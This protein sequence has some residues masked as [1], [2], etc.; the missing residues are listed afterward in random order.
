MRIRSA[1]SGVLFL[2]LASRCAGQEITATILGTVTDPSGAVVAGAT[3]IVTNTD[4]GLVAR[5]LTTSRSGDFVV[6]LLPIGH[7]EVSVEAAGFKPI[8]ETG[9][10]L[11]VNDRRAVNFVL[12][13]HGLSDEVK[14]EAEPLQVDLQSAAAAGL[15]SGTQI[16]ELASNTR[17]YTQLV[18]LQ[19]GVS[20]GLASDQPYVGATSLGGDFNHVSFSING[21]R[22][23]QNNWTLDGADNVDRGSN[24]TVLTFPSIDSIA[25]FKVLRGNYDAEFGRGSGGQINVVTRSGT[26]TFH[27]GAYEFFRSDLFAANNFFNNLNG[28]ARPPLRYNNFGFTIGGPVII[29]RLYRKKT[30]FFFSQEWRRVINYSTFTSSRVPTREELQGTFTTPVCTKPIIDPVSQLC[31]GPTTTQITDID[32]TAAAYIQDIYSKLPAPGPDGSFSFTGR[33][34][35]D[36]GEENLKIDHIF[37]P[38]L[39]A[40]FKYTHDSIPTEEPGGFLVGL[41]LPGVATTQTNSPGSNI[42]ARFATVITPRFVN[43]VG[44]SYSHGAI[45]SQPTGLLS[46][47][48][49]PDIH[50]KLPFKNLSGRVPTLG[51]FDGEGLFG[52]GPYRDLNTNHSTFDNLTWVIGRH[53][54]KYGLVYHHYEKSENS[55]FRS[56]N[57]AY[58]FLDIGPAGSSFQQEWANFLLGN[59]IVFTQSNANPVA[60]IHQNEFE[61]FAQDQYHIRSNLTLN[62]GFR[63]SLFRQPTEGHGHLSNFDPVAYDAAAAPPIDITTGNLLPNTPTPVLNGIIVGG[64]N[65]RFGN[66]IAR[67]TNRN[68]APRLAIAW[69]PFGTGK[70]SLRVGYGLFFDLPALGPFEGGTANN[71]PFLQIVT[72]SNTSLNDPAGAAVDL[73]LA[74]QGLSGVDVNWHQPYVQQWDLDFQRQLTRTMLL[75][76][77]YFGNRGLHL[78]GTLDINQPRPGAY[79]SAGVLQQG[80]INFGNSQLLNYVR[81]YRGFGP[82]NI[83]SPRFQSNYHSLQAQWQW[84]ASENNL[85]TLNY[86]WSHA[87]TDAP[88]QY[89]TP[90]NMYDIHAEYGPA[91]F[92]RRQIFTASYIY[93]LPFYRL[94]RGFT[95]H[96]LGGWEMSGI[97]YAQ[98]GLALSVIGVFTDPAGLGVANSNNGPVFDARP[99]QLADPNRHAPHTI[100]NWFDTSLFVDPPADGIRPG[101]APRG[102][103]LGPGAWRWDASLLKNTKVGEHLTV[104]FRAEATNILNHTNF[105]QVGTSYKFDPIHFGQVVSARDAR[106]I[107]LGL[108]LSF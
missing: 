1:L 88:S 58:N 13:V 54:I 37:S 106:I 72:I 52:F 79:L 62:Y 86:T 95:G 15:I 77:G 69:D 76:I 92:D 42:A 94:Q 31:V 107:Q 80:P 22:D 65:S 44:Y 46:E 17:N 53:T 70:T 60:D 12:Q 9:I 47:G 96:V 61:F 40:F 75:D 105:D 16:R 32:P 24:Q 108:K 18:L 90:Q 100:S 28:L 102:S 89:N 23:S 39:S 66:A 35:F 19:P 48:V 91:D 38:K 103:I 10:E 50:P 93:H 34:L 63:W 25:E 64:Q 74:P 71:P 11:N 83:S 73:N 27:G 67:Q 7:Y 2:L 30:F 87:L 78:P 3:I 81:P 57:G 41:N 85:L 101:N 104:Q 33:N 49:S 84:R 4:Q 59:V 29:P 8:V 26:N 21:A 5:H 99:D 20:S 82:I 36:F 97:V 45:L 56:D 6:P 43:E 14:V 68:V 98:T 51:F 55:P